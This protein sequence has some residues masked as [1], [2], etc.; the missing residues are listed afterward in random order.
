MAGAETLVDALGSAGAA[1]GSITGSSPNDDLGR[2]GSPVLENVFGASADSVGAAFGTLESVVEAGASA[3][4]LES[5]GL[6]DFDVPVGTADGSVGPETPITVRDPLGSAIDDEQGWSANEVA[7]DW[8]V[9]T[10][11]RALVDDPNEDWSDP[12]A[13]DS[14]L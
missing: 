7:D 14:P 5:D 6:I 8:S 3:A 10:D 2:D 12:G 13:F 1:I 9:A 11:G 4:G